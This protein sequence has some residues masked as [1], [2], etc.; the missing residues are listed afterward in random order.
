MNKC[1]YPDWEGGV[2]KSHHK[3]GEDGYCVICGKHD[4]LTR[5]DVTWEELGGGFIENAP[6]LPDADTKSQGE[7]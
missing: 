5:E 3:F 7:S 1:V 4:P 2:T 6:P